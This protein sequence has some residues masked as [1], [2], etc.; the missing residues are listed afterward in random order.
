MYVFAL[1]S[2]CFRWVFVFLA[3]CV[4]HIIALVFVES[5]RYIPPAFFFTVRGSGS[6]A[7]TSDSNNA[8]YFNFMATGT[9]IFFTTIFPSSDDSDLFFLRG[10]SRHLSNRNWPFLLTFRTVFIFLEQR[11]VDIFLFS[12]LLPLNFFDRCKKKRGWRR[13]TMWRVWQSGA[14]AGQIWAGTGAGRGRRGQEWQKKGSRVR[15]GSRGSGRDYGSDPTAC[16][17]RIFLA[18]GLS[19]LPLKAGMVSWDVKTNS[20]HD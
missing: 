9:F 16:S 10:V 17:K 2:V 8:R 18:L 3:G 14:V 20:C 13:Q 11:L 19:P 4:I 6:R 15:S 7:K 1:L 5:V 12:V